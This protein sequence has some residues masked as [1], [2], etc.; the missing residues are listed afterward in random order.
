MKPIVL[1]N[2]TPSFGGLYMFVCRT[3]IIK[4]R[5]CVGGLQQNLCQDALKR[6][7]RKKY[8]IG[9]ACEARVFTFQTYTFFK[10]T[11]ISFKPYTVRV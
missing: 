7:R 1:K 4:K 2:Q 10:G 3:V 11:C 8:E 5:W 9:F 6:E